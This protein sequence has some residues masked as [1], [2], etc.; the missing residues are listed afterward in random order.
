MLYPVAI[1]TW[2]LAKYSNTVLVS[3]R[4][5]GMSFSQDHLRSLRHLN[6]LSTFNRGSGIAVKQDE[7]GL[8]CLGGLQRASV[9]GSCTQAQS[10]RRLIWHEAVGRQSKMA[11]ACLPRHHKKTGFGQPLGSM[12]VRSQVFT[13]CSLFETLNAK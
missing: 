7:P 3:Y 4:K 12:L 9:L 6:K 11:K 10:A 8:T 2:F 1:D 13:A 5:T